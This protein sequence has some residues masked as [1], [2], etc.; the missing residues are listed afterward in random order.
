VLAAE[1]VKR[2]LARGLQ[3]FDFLRG[4]ERYKYQFGAQAVP[5]HNVRVINK[6]ST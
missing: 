1:L 3:Y 5:L 4:P 6:H 2:A